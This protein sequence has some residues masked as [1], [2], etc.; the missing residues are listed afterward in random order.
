MA[1]R[2]THDTVAHKR[3][4]SEADGSVTLPAAK[5]Q[6]NESPSAA[7]LV[8]GQKS[9]PK[10]IEPIT[11]YVVK[12]DTVQTAKGAF[13]QDDDTTET[14]DIYATLEDANNRVR[15]EYEE[16][17][18]E[19]VGSEGFECDMTGPGPHCWG[20][21]DTSEDEGIRVYVDEIVARGPGSEPARKWTIPLPSG[22]ESDEEESDEEE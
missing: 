18:G 8:R 19:V 5:R 22:Q 1:T 9:K 12:K 3:T 13:Y 7:L 17:G 4:R 15:L 11:I 6:S 21:E 14:L 20:V 16:Y 2:E 10:K